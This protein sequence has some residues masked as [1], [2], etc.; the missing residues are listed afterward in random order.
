MANVAFTDNQL[1]GHAR[2]WCLSSAEAG[3]RD[4]TPV[5]EV[6]AETTQIGRLSSKNMSR[7]GTIFV[8]QIYSHLSSS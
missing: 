8:V 3:S 4:V 6:D 2:F 1:G 7:Y 5:K